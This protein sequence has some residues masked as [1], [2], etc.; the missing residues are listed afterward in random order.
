VPTGAENVRSWV[1]TGSDRPTLK[2]AL[3]T[4]NGPERAA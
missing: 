1:Q 3:M 2:T 4:L